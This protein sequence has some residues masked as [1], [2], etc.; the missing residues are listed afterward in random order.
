MMYNEF[1]KKMIT[2][3]IMIDRASYLGRS[4]IV[5][6]LHCWTNDIKE[7]YPEYCAE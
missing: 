4:A 2:L 6:R 3:G 1:R 7:A 5:D